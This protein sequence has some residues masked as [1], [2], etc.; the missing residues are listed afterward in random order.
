MGSFAG[1]VVSGERVPVQLTVISTD[2]YN[3]RETN[4]NNNNI[5]A[6]ME[7]E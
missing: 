3:S 6:V 7:Y 1:I 2:R 5:A 4:N